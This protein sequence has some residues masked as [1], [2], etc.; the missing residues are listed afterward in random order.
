MTPS[1]RGQK[2]RN[3]HCIE[4][5]TLSTPV[6]PSLYQ[7]TMNFYT[8][9][10]TTI[11][12][13]KNCIEDYISDHCPRPIYLFIVPLCRVT[14]FHS[15]GVQPKCQQNNGTNWHSLF[16]HFFYSL[17]IPIRKTPRCVFLIYEP[18]A[19]HQF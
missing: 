15:L 3:K 12:R 4:K 10:F 8:D 13:E 16:Q 17:I 11:K 7:K 19:Q 14:A 2:P 1:G 18:A 6:F 9:S 5:F